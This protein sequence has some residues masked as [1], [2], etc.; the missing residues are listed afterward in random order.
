M[1]EQSVNEGRLQPVNSRRRPPQKRKPR[2]FIVPYLLILAVLMAISACTL[3]YV[4]SALEEYEASQ[5]ENIL[6]A[7]IEKLRKPG[8]GSQFEDI[9]SL[10]RMR[11]EWSASEE[12]VA[13]FK[14]DF[15]A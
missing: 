3:R 15:L 2:P 1:R 5:P 9:V 12:D 6:A 10:D 11:S 4:H 14:K 7:Q 13:Q 8:A